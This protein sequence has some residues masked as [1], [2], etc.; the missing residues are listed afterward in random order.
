MRCAGHIVLVGEI[1]NAY[2]ILVGKP[3]G[4]NHSKPTTAFHILIYAPFM[5]IFPYHSPRLC[6]SC[7]W[8]IIL[9]EQKTVFSRL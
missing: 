6:S 3:E 1:R 7:S 9:K 2:K 8:E 5:V 4:K